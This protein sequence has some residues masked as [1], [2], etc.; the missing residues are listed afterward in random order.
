MRHLARWLLR[1]LDDPNLVL[2]LAKQGGQLNS[3]FARLLG[4]RIND[5]TRLESEGKEEELRRILEA[6]PAAVPRPAMRVLWRVLQFGRVK[7]NP[8]WISISTTGS[9][10]SSR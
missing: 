5:L 9:N 7:S 2:W 6:A 1:H 4:R 10:A 3:E 8:S